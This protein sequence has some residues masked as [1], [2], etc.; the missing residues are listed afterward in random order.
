MIDYLQ[1]LYTSIILLL[2][3]FSILAVSLSREREWSQ[4]PFDIHSS[5]CE[6][7]IQQIQNSYDNLVSEYDKN[8]QTLLDNYNSMIS[9]MNKSVEG[10]EKANSV[11]S[12]LNS[13]LDV[14][15]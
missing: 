4:E 15:L 6:R 13:T 8:Y 9:T 7:N 1:M 10:N 5:Q 2:L 11:T 3:L 14:P 12:Q